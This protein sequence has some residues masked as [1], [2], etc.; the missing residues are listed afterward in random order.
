MSTT[1][2]IHYEGTKRHFFNESF[3]FFVVKKL[4]QET[5]NANV[6]HKRVQNSGI[7]RQTILSY[8]CC[9]DSVEE[10]PTEQQR[11]GK[12]EDRGLE[13]LTFWLPAR[14]SPN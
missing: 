4:A 9:R 1:A 12:V 10:S 3:A 13:P 11:S 14:R 2:D 7:D 5:G 6:Y 8:A